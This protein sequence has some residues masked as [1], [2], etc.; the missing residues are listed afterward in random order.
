MQCSRC[1]ISGLIARL[2]AVLVLVAVIAIPHFLTQ[3]RLP[4][5][6]AY[7]VDT[8]FYRDYYAW[9]TGEEAANSEYKDITWFLGM[10]PK[11][12]YKWKKTW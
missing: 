11:K 10:S 5:L 6:E 9:I 12:E 4:R 7:F 3:P 1:S 2:A 8:N